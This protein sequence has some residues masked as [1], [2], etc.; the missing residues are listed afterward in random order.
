M[1]ERHSWIL[2]AKGSVTKPLQKNVN[3]AENRE[4]ENDIDDSF[5]ECR[6]SKN[7]F[8]FFRKS[9]DGDTEERTDPRGNKRIGR[10][11][12]ADFVDSEALD[13]LDEAALP[14]R[15]SR[16]HPLKTSSGKVPPIISKIS[17]P[18]DRKGP[19]GGGL[20][21]QW[22]EHA[23][24]CHQGSWAGFRRRMVRRTSSVSKQGDEYPHLVATAEDIPPWEWDENIDVWP[25]VM[26][27]EKTL[28]SRRYEEERP[29][30]GI[31]EDCVI[32][33]IPLIE[34]EEDKSRKDMVK[35]EFKS[36]LKLRMAFAD[37]RDP[38]SNHR[39]I[40][41]LTGLKTPPYTRKYS[42]NA[43]PAKDGE[44]EILVPIALR[45]QQRGG[46]EEIG[47]SGDL[48]LMH[49]DVVNP[50]ASVA[51]AIE[52]GEAADT[53][54]NR[55]DIRGSI[56]RARTSVDKNDQADKVE[57]T[58]NSDDARLQDECEAWQVEYAKQRASETAW[59]TRLV[60]R[61]ST[62]EDLQFPVSPKISESTKCDDVMQIKTAE[63]AMATNAG[64]SSSINTSDW[65][66]ANVAQNSVQSG[67]FEL[68][69][70]KKNKITEKLEYLNVC[71]KTM[72]KRRYGTERMR[73][74]LHAKMKKSQKYCEVHGQDDVSHDHICEHRT[75]PVTPRRRVV[76]GGDESPK[77][78]RK[79]TGPLKKLLMSTATTKPISTE[80]NII[81]FEGDERV[82]SLRNSII[83]DGGGNCCTQ[84]IVQVLD[85]GRRCEQHNQVAQPAITSTA[86][87]ATLPKACPMVCD[88]NYWALGDKPLQSLAKS[89]LGSAL[90][91]VLKV[92]LRGNMLTHTGLGDILA[93]LGDHVQRI[94]LS[95][96]DFG[97]QGAKVLA[98][99]L[100]RR[101]TGLL[102]LEV[103][104]NRL[105]DVAASDMCRSLDQGCRLLQRL[106]LRDVNLGIGM[107]TGKTLGELLLGSR[108]LTTLDVSYNMLQGDGAVALLEG[109]QTSGSIS[110]QLCSFDIAWNCLGH[111][112]N[113]HEVVDALAGVLLEALGLVHF[114]VSWN[115]LNNM[116]CQILAAALENN[117]TLW[118]FHIEGNSGVLDCDGFLLPVL[119]GLATGRPQQMSVS[120]A[121]VEAD[122]EF[123]RADAIRQ[124]VEETSRV[125]V[126]IAKIKQ[127]AE[128]RLDK[129]GSAADLIDGMDDVLNHLLAFY[130]L[131]ATCPGMRLPPRSVEQGCRMWKER[132]RP[133]LGQSRLPVALAAAMMSICQRDMSWS[134]HRQAMF[135]NSLIDMAFTIS[136]RP[137]P[138]GF[139]DVSSATN[140]LEKCSK[141][142]ENPMMGD[143]AHVCWLCEGWVEVPFQVTP[144]LSCDAGFL[145]E[146]DA[147]YALLSI[148]NFHRPVPMAFVE[149]DDDD[150]DDS[151]DG[152]CGGPKPNFVFVGTRWL[153]PTSVPIFVFFIVGD[154]AFTA[155]DLPEVVLA[156]SFTLKAHRLIPDE[157]DNTKKQEIQT[158]VVVNAVNVLDPEYCADIR[159]NSE[160][161]FNDM[162]NRVSSESPQFKKPNVRK[163]MKVL[164]SIGLQHKL[165][166]QSTFI[167][168]LQHFDRKNGPLLSWNSRSLSDEL[169]LA[170]WRPRMKSNANFWVSPMKNSWREVEAEFIQTH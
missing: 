103:S 102:E 55:L 65:K 115:S 47:S 59:T 118:G 48:A 87:L 23:Q 162:A 88:F 12:T 37:A 79:S 70:P 127:S 136:K 35:T 96:N 101:A 113:D 80:N 50:M 152:I 15:A 161:Q 107:L 112:Q 33:L 110:G 98:E 25:E 40:T 144:G 66:R 76:R 13:T 111:G 143:I 42:E 121:E 54:I 45:A 134:N 156:N 51:S 10:S 165:N 120:R 69:A 119:D 99:Y 114:D 4:P 46:P 52:S 153:P 147:V 95:E 154:Q 53:L 93:N 90:E 163:S 43:Q 92:G 108:W 24:K 77:P 97:S 100:R 137:K 157:K 145:S 75:V 85:Y 9:R 126:E 106:C 41:A 158:E 18:L 26:R 38:I 135:S 73:L 29:Q 31:I 150:S 169:E 122:Y 27:A 125:E 83:S 57:R 82:E 141:H 140:R 2:K 129:K 28:P 146:T 130:G 167:S 11:L 22:T 78:V 170:R 67:W 86:F 123:T 84:Q 20:G 63:P 148:D 132:V 39:S 91:T 105:G 151:D 133:G 104:H 131:E 8:A 160:E 61:Q 68:E 117:S 14:C 6:K 138:K 16:S 72:G 139:H 94:D 164:G 49:L 17:D 58:A 62:W 89:S 155:S 56:G 3:F 32:D 71:R 142:R 7:S 81:D 74:E 60:Q 21:S 5:A 1:P 36:D 128:A 159:K 34:E 44:R 168:L 149:G 19:G 109:V 166:R 124:M 116:H 30:N 64:H